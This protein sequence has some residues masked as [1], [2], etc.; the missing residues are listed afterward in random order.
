[1]KKDVY[2]IRNSSDNKGSAKLLLDRL[3]SNRK[4]IFED[5]VAIKVHF[6]EK[7]NVTYIKPDNYD[8]IIDYLQERDVIT[9]FIE[10]NVLYLGSRTT[11]TDHLKV[12]KDHGF[13]RI[14]IVIADGDRGEAYTEVEI[15]KEIFDKALIGEGFDNFKQIVVTA[16]FKGHEMAG[17]GGAL[18]QLAM[19]F[20]ARGGKLAQHSDNIPKI[21][22]K[23]CIACNECVNDCPVQAITVNEVARIDPDICI[24]CAAC[25]P[26]CP[27]KTIR[28]DWGANSRFYEK[29]A[30]YAYAAQKD[31]EFLYINF[32]T[33]ITEN[34]DCMGEVQ[35]PIMADIGVFASFDPVALDQ[36]CFDQVKAN[37]DICSSSRLWNYIDN[38]LITL[39]H[40]E[41]IGFGSRDYNLIIIEK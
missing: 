24:G 4:L 16:H 14:P 6:G 18:K 32:V 40:C 22:E 7:G 33:N 11:K 2:F 30:E 31:K 19:G 12:A 21:I 26:A 10:T 37:K 5:Q 13:T 15:N 41:K 36:A 34:C 27:T 23:G 29:V 9:S 39:E 35:H 25:I 17:F 8:G 1:M 3:C 38:G 20:A 28:I